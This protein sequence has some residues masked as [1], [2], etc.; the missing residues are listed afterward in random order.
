[1]ATWQADFHV[2]L[3]NG[4]PSDY[5]ERIGGL[6]PV[7]QSW[8][9]NIEMWGT[10][11]GDRVDVACGAEIP[12]EVFVRF[13]LRRWQPELYVRFVAILGELGGELYSADGASVPLEADALQDALRSSPA[14]AFVEN[15]IAFLGNLSRRAGPAA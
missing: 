9:D 5:R 12:G 3:S 11:D 15:P 7:A 1:M 10:E 14:A 13:D 4:L 8:T 6:L 2:V